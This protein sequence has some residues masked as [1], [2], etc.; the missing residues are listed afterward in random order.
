MGCCPVHGFAGVVAP[1][2]RLF[3]MNRVGEVGHVRELSRVDALKRDDAGL[4]VHDATVACGPCRRIRSDGAAILP[5][6]FRA[7]VC[8]PATLCRWSG[9]GVQAESDSPFTTQRPKNR[10]CTT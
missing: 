5:E 6:A 10:Y 4:D 1:E 3:A 9:M 2:T 7:I 8:P